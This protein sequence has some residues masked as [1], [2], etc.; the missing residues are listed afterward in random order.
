MLISAGRP[1]LHTLAGA[2][3][4][5]CAGTVWTLPGLIGLTGV[6]DGA[7]NLAVPLGRDSD[8]SKVYRSA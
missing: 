6:L 8:A 1:L 4:L 2:L 7:L 5:V 3:G